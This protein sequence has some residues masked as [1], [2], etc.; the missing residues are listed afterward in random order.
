MTLCI[1]GEMYGLRFSARDIVLYWE[2]G[3]RISVHTSRI[4]NILHGVTFEGT[5]ISYL[6]SQYSYSIK[7]CQ[8]WMLIWTSEGIHFV[9]WNPS[10]EKI[11]LDKVIILIQVFKSVTRNTLIQLRVWELSKKT[12]IFEEG[13]EPSVS[14][15][16][17]VSSSAQYL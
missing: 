15:Q 13:N 2:T 10:C 8:S 12:G 4:S 1:L 11:Y 5:L 9:G 17:A 16:Q 7:Y 3:G 6:M 14:V